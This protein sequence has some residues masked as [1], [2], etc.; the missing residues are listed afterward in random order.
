MTHLLDSYFNET[1]ALILKTKTHIQELETT[2]NKDETLNKIL[3][4][5]NQQITYAENNN[6]T[7]PELRNYHHD[8]KTNHLSL[9]GYIEILKK[10]TDKD[11]QKEHY[12]T[13]QHIINRD[14]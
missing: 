8:L 3:D 4:D 9:K 13:L 5:V 6:E 1:L 12:K 14:L 2:E 11:K 7:H 10:E